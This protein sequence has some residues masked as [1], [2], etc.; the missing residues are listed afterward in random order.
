MMRPSAVAPKEPPA[1]NPV[2]KTTVAIVAGTRTGL[3]M[4]KTGV[5]TTNAAAEPARVTQAKPTKITEATEAIIILITSNSG[6]RKENILR[7]ENFLPSLS[8]RDREGKNLP[9]LCDRDRKGNLFLP[10]LSDRD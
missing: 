5:L 4:M 7:K 1:V 8:E 2:A 10:S 9:S 3:N 6:M